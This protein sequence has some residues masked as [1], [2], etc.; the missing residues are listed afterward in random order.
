MKKIY[1]KPSTFSSLRQYLTMDSILI[2]SIRKIH[3][4]ISQGKETTVRKLNVSGIL[5]KVDC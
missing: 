2:C 4:Y 3:K 5:V 1:F